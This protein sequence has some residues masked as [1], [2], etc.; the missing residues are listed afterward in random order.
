MCIAPVLP[1]ETMKNLLLQ[2][3][4]VSDP[5]KNPL[6]GWWC[7]FYFFYVKHRDLDDRDV[8]TE[9][10]VNPATTT[11]S[12]NEATGKE[13]PDGDLACPRG[14]LHGQEEPYARRSDCVDELGGGWAGRAGR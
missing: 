13:R 4:V 2:A 12:L 14:G 6:I 9:M 7:E 3:R 11:S 5:I 8:F 10:M 1:G